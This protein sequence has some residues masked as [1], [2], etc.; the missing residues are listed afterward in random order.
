MFITII[1]LLFTNFIVFLVLTTA[2]YFLPTGF[3]I[4]VDLAILAVLIISFIKKSLQHEILKFF[5]KEQKYYKATNITLTV[6]LLFTI[7]VALAGYSVE[8]VRDN[9]L[10]EK[11]KK[12][13]AIKESKEKTITKDIKTADNKVDN[14]TIDEKP[15]EN[16]DEVKEQNKEVVND[17]EP[18]ED[19]EQVADEEIKLVDTEDVTAEGQFNGTEPKAENDNTVEQE[20]QYQVALKLFRAKKYEEAV[21]KFYYYRCC[22]TQRILYR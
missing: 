17:K 12:L 19:V 11:E 6:T 16:P 7:L 2:A 1:K 4:L 15:V 5:T 10:A 22:W 13:Q 20:K 14:N 3:M 8:S 18:T 9:Q 21:R